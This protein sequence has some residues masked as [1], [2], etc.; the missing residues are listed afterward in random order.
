MLVAGATVACCLA[1]ASL[2]WSTYNPTQP[3]EAQ[4]STVYWRADTPEKDYKAVNFG[5]AVPNTDSVAI[6][7]VA[8]TVDLKDGWHGLYVKV[9]P[10]TL[11]AAARNPTMM[12]ATWFGA[13]YGEG[14]ATADLM[15]YNYYNRHVAETSANFTGETREWID[16]HIAFMY[17]GAFGTPANANSPYWAQV[18]KVLLQIEGLQAGYTA[19]QALAAAPKPPLAF[20]DVFLLSFFDETADVERSTYLSRGAPIPEAVQ[21][22]LKEMGEHCSALIKLVPKDIFVSH[23]TW[24]SLSGLLRT[25]K[26]YHI[27]SF[28][29]QMSSHPGNLAS[30]D[31]YYYMNDGLVA[32]ETT[33]HN[34]NTSNWGL[35]KAESVSEF[36]RALVSSYLAKGDPATW[37]NNFCVA[38][39]NSGTY[40]NQYMIVQLQ[41]LMPSSDGLRPAT[42]KA[43]GFVMLEQM[44]GACIVGDQTAHLNTNGYWASYNRPF[45]PETFEG[46]NW[47]A[48]ERISSY[49]SYSQ[50]YRAKIFAR[51]QPTVRTMNDMKRLMRYNDYKN[52]E[53]SVVPD[54][55]ECWP[56]HTPYLSIAARCDL[57][58]ANGS[59]GVLD[60]EISL[61]NG[62][63][64]DAKITSLAS[65]KSSKM[66]STIAM[67]PPFGGPSELKPFTFSTTAVTP[68]PRNMGLPDKIEYNYTSSNQLFSEVPAA[69]P[70]FT[71]LPTTGAS[72]VVIR[73]QVS[74]HTFVRSTFGADLKKTLLR[75][76]NY[77]D[78]TGKT[79]IELVG[80][81][82][83]A[84][85]IE[86]LVTLKG[87]EAAN[88]QNRLVREGAGALS[89][90]D[91]FAIGYGFETPLVADEK[92]NLWIIGLVVA[93]FMGLVIVVL[94]F[95]YIRRYEAIEAEAKAPF[96]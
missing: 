22:R 26:T 46:L 88:W 2:G 87:P 75:K 96:S 89:S 35:I 36:V 55:P 76:L 44:P 1:T 3:T 15:Y 14:Y 82:W 92:S 62:A 70:D 95:R 37:A 85:H 38:D 4:F 53:L 69:V 28:V 30:S 31:D 61:Q 18:G 19:R 9:D 13:G 5:Y 42:L 86:A 56:Q 90:A 20:L 45:Y 43:G 71:R 29:L 10:A 11:V 24:N 27:G 65:F 91:L 17:R 54:C 94:L 72:I 63:A 33:N 68:K 51:E 64:I 32:Q 16:R 48:M 66:L 7:K 23:A 74:A 78:P 47:T 40:N 21:R 80:A 79:S 6:A 49:Y 73:V 60:R 81:H 34:H 52:D 93:S 50:N 12:N 41:A 77:T 67:G 39:L 8:A 59:F 83:Y 25:F 58:P 84:K 57:V